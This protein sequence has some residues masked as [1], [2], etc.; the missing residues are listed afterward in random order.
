MRYTARAVAILVCAVVLWA[1]SLACVLVASLPFSLAA[2]AIAV[3]VWLIAIPFFVLAGNVILMPLYLPFRRSRLR[4]A[5]EKTRREN[6]RI[7]TIAG[8]FGKTTTKYFLYELARYH[9][10]TQMVA[11]NVNTPLGIAQWVMK[12]LRPGTEILIAEVDTYR[13]GEIQESCR[14]VPADIAILTTIGDQHLER[15]PS[16]EHLAKALSEVFTC[17]KPNAKLLCPPDVAKRL[18]PVA[19]S[20]EMITVDTRDA[21]AELHAAGVSLACFSPSNCADLALAVRAAKLLGA[22]EKFIF[23]TCK[24]LEP[25][26]RRQKITVWHGYDCLDDSYNISFATAQAGIA[27]AQDL[28]HKKGKKLLAITAGIPELGQADKAN[29]ERLGALLA[30]RA[31]HVVILKSMFAWDIV[32]GVA[33]RGKCTIVRNLATFL[34]TAERQFPSTQW[35]IF[36]EPELT[37]LYY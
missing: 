25:P 24:H 29:N 30:K 21:M 13:I 4:E 5:E 9:A 7:V 14:I 2:G 17:A 6:L 27:A 20:R 15:F 31:D 3:A 10:A 37:D 12:E 35:A 18:G 19:G 11:G 8:S 22:P 23:D 1:A 34:A 36:L 33:D 28:A 16:A 26:D 32:R